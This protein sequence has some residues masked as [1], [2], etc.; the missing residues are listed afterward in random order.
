[1]AG[2]RE[3]V[4]E[5]IPHPARLSKPRLRGIRDGTFLDKGTFSVGR[6]NELSLKRRYTSWEGGTR[7]VKRRLE[8]LSAQSHSGTRCNEL[9]CPKGHLTGVREDE[10]FRNSNSEYKTI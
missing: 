3:A 9:L 4:A 7:H 6:R 1:V 2:S 10:L 5:L 8:V